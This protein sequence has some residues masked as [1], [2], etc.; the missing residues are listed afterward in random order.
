[1]GLH[2]PDKF[3]IG[4]EPWT[5]YFWAVT[6]QNVHM[7]QRPSHRENHPHFDAGADRNRPKSTD[8]DL[9]K[10]DMKPFAVHLGQH[11]DYAPFPCQAYA[12][13]QHQSLVGLFIGVILNS[14]WTA[15]MH[16][17]IY[18]WR[19]RFPKDSPHIKVL[20]GTLCA[21]T[22]LYNALISDARSSSDASLW[23]LN[24]MGPHKAL[25]TTLYQIFFTVRLWLYGRDLRFVVPLVLFVATTAGFGIFN[26]WYAWNRFAEFWWQKTAVYALILIT[27]ILL[28]GYLAFL[29][30]R[31]RSRFKSTESM[32]YLIMVYGVATGA[33]TSVLA[34][35]GLISVR[36]RFRFFALI[37][38]CNTAL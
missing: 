3:P 22:L 26:A 15:V 1:M 36:A 11:V 37:T 38:E 20:I 35:V 12:L 2:S 17:Q 29:M 21:S 13:L 16:I 23:E 6:S 27:D 24:W 33:I 7:A 25:V 14:F 32:M 34:L 9:Q 10:H 8:P 30:F 28:S 4:T 18:T 19:R 31:P 5:P